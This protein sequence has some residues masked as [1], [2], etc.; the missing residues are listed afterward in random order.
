MYPN[1]SDTPSARG[2]ELVPFKPQDDVL[3]GVIVEGHLGVNFGLQFTP[4][5]PPVFVPPAFAPYTYAGPSA[6]DI[7]K[8]F[9]GVS[10]GFEV[11]VT[12]FDEAASALL[13]FGE[14]ARQAG[15]VDEE[16]PTDPRARAIWMK[17]HRNH[18][19]EKPKNWRKR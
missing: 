1:S 15:L 7:R 8:T 3:E 16:P 11:I 18:G 17:Q 13:Y 2:G 5:P 10:K 4:P 12:W 19:P 6:E 9:L 14:A